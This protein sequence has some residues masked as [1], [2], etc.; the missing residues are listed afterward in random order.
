MKMNGFLYFLGKEE[1]LKTE[2]KEK[3]AIDIINCP[4]LKEV[5]RKNKISEATLYRL[6]QEPDFR[7]IL[8][9]KRVEMY[10]SALNAAHSFGLD[11]VKRLMEIVN[12]EELPATA[13][14]NA[15]KAII[16]MCSNYYDNAAILTRIEELEERYNESQDWE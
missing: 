16:E 7:E 3:I 5:C 6:R 10:E 11:C 9:Q 12:K 1:N 15:A 2:R 4:T 14:V 13:R 8:N